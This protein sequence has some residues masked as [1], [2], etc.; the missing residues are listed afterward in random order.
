MLNRSGIRTKSGASATQ[1]LAD[2]SMQS[3]IGIIVE[4]AAGVADGD[5]KIVKAGTPLI[6]DATNTQTPAKV[7]T[8]HDD[9]TNGID[10]ANVVLL[11]DVDVTDGNANG[12]GLVIGIV[13]WSRLAASVQALLKPG[14]AVSGVFCINLK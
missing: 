1:I 14:D 3:S 2:V 4:A 13:N 12:T 9:E 11:H 6:I 7:I 10:K 8:S 5:R